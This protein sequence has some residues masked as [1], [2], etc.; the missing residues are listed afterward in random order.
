MLGDDYCLDNIQY[1]K[2]KYFRYRW[3]ILSGE[4]KEAVPNFEKKL[5]SKIQF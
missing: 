5:F 2:Y 3:H 1:K 4:K